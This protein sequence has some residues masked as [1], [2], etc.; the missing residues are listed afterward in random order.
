MTYAFVLCALGL[1]WFV[2]WRWSHD[3]GL[4]MFGSASKLPNPPEW[5]RR[6]ARSDDGELNAFALANEVWGLLV[7]ALAVILILNPPRDRSAN[8]D[9]FL[10]ILLSLALTMLCA[11]T[12][13]LWRRIRRG[14]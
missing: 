4:L 2:I 3:R 7:A 12:Y 13:T 9:T 8:Y 6:V 1:F 5:L 14:R 11:G 10:N